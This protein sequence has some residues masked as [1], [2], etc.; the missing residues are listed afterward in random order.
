MLLRMCEENCL[1]QLNYSEDGDTRL[2]RNVS[3]HLCYIPEEHR[4]TFM[5]TVT[6]LLSRLNVHCV[7]VFDSM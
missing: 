7:N 4:L 2:P 6:V 5:I 3:N 1:P